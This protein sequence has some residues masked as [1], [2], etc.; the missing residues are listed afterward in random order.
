MKLCTALFTFAMVM[1]AAILRDKNELSR[2][3]MATVV[4]VKINMHTYYKLTK[5]YKL[6]QMGLLASLLATIKSLD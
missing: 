3:N 5:V 4:M 1:I 6:I 2:H